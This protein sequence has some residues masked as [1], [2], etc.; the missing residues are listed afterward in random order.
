MPTNFPRPAC[1]TGPSKRLLAFLIL[2]ASTAC[3][4]F[5]LPAEIR[6][7]RVRGIERLSFA[8]FDNNPV[9]DDGG[10]GPGILDEIKETLTQE[11]N[12]E[13]ESA[14]GRTDSSELEVVI[15]NLSVL[16]E[17]QH[18]SILRQLNI[19]SLDLDAFL[20][21]RDVQFGILYR[22][23][24]WRRVGNSL[25]EI[26]PETPFFRVTE[27]LNYFERSSG[28]WWI[29]T[30]TLFPYYDYYYYDAASVAETLSE[31]LT[32]SLAEQLQ[33]ELR[34]LGRIRNEVQ[35]P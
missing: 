15:T 1:R 22:F 18:F 23:E 11:L 6:S 7:L 26:V 30:L 29:I 12:S 32:R 33:N 14:E 35:H 16:L 21:A 2:L 28:W 9:Y 8:G 10:A 25:Q 27:K 20:L 17:S 19:F 34:Q 4:S 13:I 3:S 31:A 24:V 5:E